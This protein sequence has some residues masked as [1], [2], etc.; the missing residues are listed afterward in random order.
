[1]RS[2]DRLG[3]LGRATVARIWAMWFVVLT[4]LPFTAPFA[5]LD[6]PD[7]WGHPRAPRATTTVSAPGTSSPQADDSA[8]DVATSDAC[9]QRI[10][11]TSRCARTPATSPVVSRAFP[12]MTALVTSAGPAPPARN[13]SALVV[14]L[15]L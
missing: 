6:L 1:M 2:K 9:G 8:D 5:T 7:L 15:R 14:T 10:V 4:A 12:T 13:V 3:T 11:P